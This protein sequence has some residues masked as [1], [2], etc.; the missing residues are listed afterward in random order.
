MQFTLTVTYVPKKQRGEAT[1]Q[2]RCCGDLLVEDIDAGKMV[3][4]VCKRSY[5]L[6]TVRGMLGQAAQQL[7]TLTESLE[8]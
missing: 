2:L 7:A 6:D 5:S 1:A 8:G 4:R 3:C